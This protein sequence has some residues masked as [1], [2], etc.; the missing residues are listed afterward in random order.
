MEQD[1]GVQLG[2]RADTEHSTV[3]LQTRV[4]CH[5]TAFS[6]KERLLESVAG[7]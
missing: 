7:F 5:D 1:Q 2:H 4:L 3:L 6:S